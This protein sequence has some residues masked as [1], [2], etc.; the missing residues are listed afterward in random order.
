M[1]CFSWGT[2]LE[3]MH[4]ISAHVLLARPQSND[5]NGLSAR[6]GDRACVEGEGEANLG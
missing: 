6:L 4:I 5:P 3:M 1:R 2:D